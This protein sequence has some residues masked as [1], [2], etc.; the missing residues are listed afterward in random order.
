MAAQPLKKSLHDLI[1]KINDEDLLKAYLCV[2]RSSVE[3]QVDQVNEDIVGYT[4]KGEALTKQKLNEKVK[5]ASKRVKGGD[6][7]SHR[8]VVKDAKSW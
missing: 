4:T 6:F 1:D 2:I 7:I 3:D 8:D 5:A